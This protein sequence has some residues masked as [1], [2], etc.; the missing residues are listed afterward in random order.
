MTFQ[1]TNE[2]TRVADISP[3][4]TAELSTSQAIKSFQS[5]VSSPTLDNTLESLFSGPELQSLKLS[6]PTNLAS[7]QAQKQKLP[8]LASEISP[9]QSLFIIYF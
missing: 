7:N 4:A 8:V 5:K 9:G 3:D 1:E 6:L 2:S